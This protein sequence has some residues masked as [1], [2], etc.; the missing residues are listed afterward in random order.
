MMCSLQMSQ[1]F[2]LNGGMAGRGFGEGGGRDLRRTVLWREAG[3]AEEVSWYGEEFK[4]MRSQIS[5][6][7]TAVSMLSP[8]LTMLSTTGCFHSSTSIRTLY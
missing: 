4:K 6:C 2:V 5:F 1:G 3:M 7:L 8:T